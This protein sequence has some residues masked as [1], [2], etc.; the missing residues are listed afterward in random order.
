MAISIIEHTPAMTS[1]VVGAFKEIIPVSEGFS[2]WFPRETT[3][4][5]YVDIRVRRGTRKIATDVVRFTEGKATKNAKITESKYLP[6][7]YELEYFFNHDEIYMRSLEFGTLSSPQ[8]NK[9]ISQNAL[10][11]L[12]EQRNMIERA[13]RKQQAQVF[14]TGVITL[15]N[16]DSIDFKRKAESIVDVSGSNPYWNNAS[17][18]KPLD[19]IAAGGVFLRNTGTALGNE[20]NLI[21]R[22]GNISKLLATDQ[23]KELGDYKWI[24]RVNIGFPEFTE[25]TG[26]TF[27]GQVAAGDFRVNLW[28]YD[29][30]YENEDGTNSYYL[31]DDNVILLPKNFEGKTIFG[32]LPGMSNASIDGMA[33]KVPAAIE[34]EFLIVPFYNERTISSGIKMSSAPIV[35]PITVDRIFTMKVIA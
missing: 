10:D 13:V 24:E 35:I 3:P 23:V 25:S 9:L 34:A 2:Q 6:P 19:D 22:S 30:I 1:K 28:S 8:A 5:F 20:L 31:D 11:N 17:T 27:H 15:I 21:T 7:Y 18:A 4:S 29:D 32:A 33:T 12:V 26:F 14:Q 16:G